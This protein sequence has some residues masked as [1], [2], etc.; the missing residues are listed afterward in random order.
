MKLSYPKIIHSKI[1]KDKRGF[2][3]EIYKEK[4]TIN[5]FKFSL[6]VNSKKNV[7]RG[8][9]FQ[10][11]KQQKKTIIVTQGELIDFCLDLRKKSPTFKKIFKFKLKQNSILLIPKGF[12]HG[13]LTLKD[14]TQMIYLLSE[15]RFKNDERTLDIY[16][17][18]LNLQLNKNLI[19]SKKDKKGMSLEMFQKSIK[20]L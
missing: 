3:Q 6:L 14:N 20:S 11:K 18:S 4:K 12:A 2:L 19:V 15:H 9:H 1:F 17:K 10:E 7:F 16:D 8:F 13:Y 5:N